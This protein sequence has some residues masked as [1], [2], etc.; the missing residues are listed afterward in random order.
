[1]QGIHSKHPCAFL[2]DLIIENKFDQSQRNPF[3]F[4]ALNPLIK[5]TELPFKMSTEYG[6]I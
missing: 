6:L 3:M 2:T 4:L 1:M 5:V